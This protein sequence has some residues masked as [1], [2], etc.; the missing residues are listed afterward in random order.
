MM[1]KIYKENIKHIKM[2]ILIV[3]AGL[4]GSTIAKEL[5]NNGYKCCV[6][7]KR[8]HIGGNCYTEN[9][10]GIN[11]HKY[12]PHIFHTSNNKLR[13]YLLKYTSI[14]QFSCRPKLRY[15]NKLFSFP[16]NLMTMNQLW[17][18]TTPEEGK[19]RLNQETKKYKKS[20]YKNAEEW[21][22][23]NV[24]KEI[25]EIFYKGYLTKQWNKNPKDIPPE[26]MMRQVIRLDYNDSYYYDIYQGI[27]DYNLLFNNLLYNIPVELNVNYLDNKEYFNSKYDKIVYT[28]TIDEFFNYEYG[29]LEY[30]SLRFEEEI[31]SIKDYQGVFMVSYPEKKYPFTRIIE[32]KHFEFGDQNFTII[33][34]EYPQ[35]WEIGKESFYPINNNKN[36]IIF[37]KYNS[38]KDNKIIFGGRLGSYRYLNMDQTIEQALNLSKII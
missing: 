10:N 34:R 15:K 25:Y 7:D 14:N 38:Y 22:L 23:G 26:I 19:K 17:G 9:I 35:N 3:G 37:E 8:N 21:A 31:L 29:A 28:G 27:P 1:A 2:K 6:I 18:I 11:V 5:T 20:I 32:H 36:Q 24:G 4:F 13:E 12:G 30:R 16:V 33:T